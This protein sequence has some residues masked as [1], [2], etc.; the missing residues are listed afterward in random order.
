MSGNELLLFPLPK[1][2]SST[3]EEDAIAW[4]NSTKT[5]FYADGFMS[6]V[7]GRKQLDLPKIDK[8]LKDKYDYENKGCCLRCSLEKFVTLTFGEEISYLLTKWTLIPEEN[9]TEQ[10]TTVE[11]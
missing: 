10:N 1:Y 4:E 6:A 8:A 5:K 3:F 7:C 2:Y 11:N 9:G